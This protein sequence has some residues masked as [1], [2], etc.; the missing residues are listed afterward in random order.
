ML[1]VIDDFSCKV[2]VFFVKQIID[3]FSTFKDWKKMIEKKTCSDSV[4]Q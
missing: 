3:V 1:T 2:W 4:P